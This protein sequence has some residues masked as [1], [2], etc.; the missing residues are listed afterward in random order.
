[1]FFLYIVV[2]VFYD[3]FGFSYGFIYVYILYLDGFIMIFS[4][5][6]ELCR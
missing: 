2:F 5:K 6:I 4:F 3:L 1:M